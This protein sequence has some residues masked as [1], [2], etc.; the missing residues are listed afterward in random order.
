MKNLVN[1]NCGTAVVEVVGRFTITTTS[2][3]SLGRLVRYDVV[4]SQND[5]VI[6]THLGCIGEESAK[7]WSSKLVELAKKLNILYDAKEAN[8]AEAEF[9]DAWIAR[10][11]NGK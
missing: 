3:E 5:K 9:V 1:V 2:Q 4:L 11:I 8:P 7:Y 6:N 10:L